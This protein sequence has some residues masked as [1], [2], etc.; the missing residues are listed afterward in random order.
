M[1]K[2]CTE[3][4]ALLLG[5]D[6]QIC[7][8]LLT[9]YQ[10]VLFIGIHFFS[11][12]SFTV[13]K[14]IHITSGNVCL[15]SYFCMFQS[16]IGFLHCYGSPDEASPQDRSLQQR[17]ATPSHTNQRARRREG[18]AGIPINN[19]SQKLHFLLRPYFLNVLLLSSTPWS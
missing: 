9:Y 2:C 4:G 1:S 5:C 14:I 10:D 11:H 3:F 15:G 17:T 13:S 6:F 18:Q 16:V 12:L 8:F 7:P 19:T